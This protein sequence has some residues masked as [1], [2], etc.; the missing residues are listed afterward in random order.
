MLMHSLNEQKDRCRTEI[1][2]KLEG[3]C[4]P[5]FYRDLLDTKRARVLSISNTRDKLQNKKKV[6]K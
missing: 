3:V 1:C 5:F 4:P 6:R 2:R